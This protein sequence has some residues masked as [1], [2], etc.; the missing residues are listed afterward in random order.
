MTVASTV[1]SLIC[2]ITLIVDYVRTRDFRHSGSG[3]TEKQRSLVIAVMILLCYIGL[4]S[5]CFSFLVSDLTC[6]S[7]TV[8]PGTPPSQFELTCCALSADIDSLYF[9]IVTISE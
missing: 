1:A 5:L 8:E 6:E 9:T 3:L 4:G 7:P 2:N